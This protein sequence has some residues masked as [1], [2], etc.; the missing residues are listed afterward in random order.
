VR[1]VVR[2]LALSLVGVVIALLVAEVALRVVGLS[3]F[4]APMPDPTV[5]VFH[6]PGSRGWFLSEGRDYVVLNSQGFRDREH[7]VAK[8]P[9]VLRVAVLGDSFAEAL[10]LPMENSFWSVLGRSLPSCAALAGR[11]VEV[12]NFGVG[13]YGTTQQLLMLRSRVW[14]YQPDVVVLAFYANDVEDNS[15]QLSDDK[16]RPFFVPQDGALVLD[17]SFRESSSYRGSDNPLGRVFF[18]AVLPN[19]AVLRLAFQARFTAK[20]RALPPDRFAAGGVPPQ[21]FAEPADPRWQEAWLVTEGVVTRFAEEVA[22]GGARFLLLNV[23]IPIQV[24]PDAEVRTRFANE[25]GVADL[26]YPNARIA[27]LAARIRAPFLDTAPALGRHAQEQRQPVHGFDGRGA[28]HWNEVGH[29]L[30][31]E[32]TAGKLCEE[33]SR[34]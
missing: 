17:N 23:S 19:S 29:R 22:A 11:Q 27:A 26:T 8:P 34:G 12:L 13:G 14:A 10:Q 9:N 21:L 25:L 15:R 33:L 7:S 6:P 24:H 30:A 4:R 31:G 5:G 28:G 16:L 1:G 32:L 20:V 2:R 18:G 3:Y